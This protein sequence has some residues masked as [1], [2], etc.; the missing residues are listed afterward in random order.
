MKRA[1]LLMA[2]TS[3]CLV[4]LDLRSE[5]QPLATRVDHVYVESD[6]A[7]SL[8]TFFKDTF[9]LPG[10]WPFRDA[11]THTS[12]GLW[13]G[14]TVLEFASSPHSGDKPVRAEFRGI[15]FEPTGGADETAA[16]LT[17][18]GISRREVENNMRQGS[19]GQ[20]RV[21]WS[22]VHLKDFPPIEA[23]VFFVDYKFRKSAAARY[24]AADDKLTA[25]NRGPLG[26]IGAAE[27]TVGVQNLE[28]TRSKW[29][30]LLAPSP[31]IS[32]NAFV[33]DSGPRIRLVHAESPGIQGI[34]LK[35]RSLDQ[36]ANFLGER[37]LLAKD[38]SGRVAIFPAAIDG[39]SIRLIDDSQTE[40]SGNP[41]LG[42][43]RGVDHVGIAVRDLEK[44]RR[45]YEQVLGF[46][47]TENLP[48]VSGL[49]RYIVFLGDE[50]C[51]EFLSPSRS[52]SAAR[53]DF[54]GF[55]E[56]HEGGLSLALAT[57]SA[58]RA[59]DYL[60]AHNFEVKIREWPG[61][62]K[63]GETK[64]AAVQY[65]SVSSPDSPSGNKQVFKVWIWLV[66]YVSP[67]RAARRAARREQGLMAHPNAAQRL[68][69]VWFAVRDLE[70]SL[71]NLQDAGLE[72]GEPREAKFLGAQGREVKAGSGVM[73]LLRSADKNGALNKFLS[74][75]DDG[76]II[77]VSIE[78]SDLNKAR[79]WVEGHSGHKLEPYNGFYGRAI[80]VPPD[81][82]H[83][84]WL[85][86]FERRS[87]GH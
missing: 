84:V 46:K 85:E 40:E 34:V 71:R 74:D 14:N 30:V 64:P 2:A 42:H 75:H 39:L 61:P 50:T 44:A 45:D 21:V 37:G 22:I 27:I 73:I 56:R 13:L 11:G 59:A 32:D 65:Y 1:L 19:D 76:D 4:A 72:P 60:E 26:I 47:C 57:S 49:L 51:L 10:V 53:D 6:K 38:D 25:I 52:T 20:T 87:A 63:E 8:F 29:T 7:Q 28:E 35:V 36:A 58:K 15:A 79:S 41:L 9:Q 83:G 54:R 23:D 31:H 18:R 68:Y 24:K 81:L 66:E 78:V 55:V 33:F 82:T 48:T 69:A 12:G 16:E 17:K 3:L 5:E 80:M 86:L 43:G 70:A 77:G 67:E 62:T